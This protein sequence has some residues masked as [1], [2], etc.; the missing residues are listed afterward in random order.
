MN[1]A[2]LKTVLWVCLLSFILLACEGEP[3]TPPRE[4]P[5]V[6]VAAGDISSCASRGDEAT[7][8]LLGAI[9]GTILALGDEAYGVL[10]LTL[11]PAS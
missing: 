7:A 1:A 2:S 5:A 11:H 8:K 10:K 3:R 4:P 6:V 9:H